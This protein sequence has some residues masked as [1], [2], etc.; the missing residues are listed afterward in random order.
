MKLRLAMYDRKFSVLFER[1]FQAL[2]RTLEA[3]AFSRFVLEARDL[4]Q[5]LSLRG[6]KRMRVA[7]LHEAARLVTDEPVAGL[8]EAA[9]S[10]KLLQTHALIHD[11]II[12]NSPTRRGGPSTY[13][14]YRARLPHHP[15]AALGLALLAG[16]LALNLSQQVLMDSAATLALRHGMVGIQLHAARAMFTGQIADMERDFT[17]LP[18]EDMLHSVAEYK[19]A[20]YSA[21]APM[22]L[23]LLAAGERPTRFHTALH[24]YTRSIG[25]SEQMR[26]DYQDLYGDAAAMGKPT[27][28][29]IRDGRRNY[30][31]R[32][33]L[34]AA[35]DEE[36]ALVE[37]ILGSPDCTDAEISAVA[38]VG[39]R[40]DVPR[41]LR[42][43]MRHFAQ[44]AAAEAASWRHHWREDAVAFFERLPAW[45]LE[46]TS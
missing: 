27:G 17:S 8:D 25:I 35:T 39:R 16:D 9:L 10:I 37:S 2:T 1:Y 30:A 12:D 44:Q 5:D 40:H 19:S 22:Q 24:R 14:A 32:A 46:R 42:E 43:Q 15:Q 7:L 33:I 18:D 21:L 11:D 13:Y 4:L 29:D 3:P 26:D 20:R 41:E 6:G 45:S 23:G 34:T 38:D 28:T 36:R 31:V